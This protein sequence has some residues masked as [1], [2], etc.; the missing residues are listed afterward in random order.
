MLNE[1]S[2]TN[3][4]RPVTRI[5]RGPAA[6]PSFGCGFAKLVHAPHQVLAF[7]RADRL[8]IRHHQKDSHR[9]IR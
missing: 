5:C 1:I 6:V 4:E 8:L 2:D 7:K 9:A 3:A